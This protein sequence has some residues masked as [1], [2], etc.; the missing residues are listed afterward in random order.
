MHAR[1]AYRGYGSGYLTLFYLLWVL[2]D[3]V[4]MIVIGLAVAD[5]LVDFRSRWQQKPDRKDSDNE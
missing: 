4:K 3:P 2:L 5:S 1:A